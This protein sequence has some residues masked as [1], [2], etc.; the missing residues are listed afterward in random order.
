[1]K[2]RLITL[3]ALGLAA[4]QPR[5]VLPERHVPPGT[6]SFPIG[7]YTNCARG[8]GTRGPSPNA[9]LNAAGFESGSVLTLAQSGTT[10]QAT[11]VDWNG[12]TQSAS[13]STTTVTSAT[14][15]PAGQVIPGF[16]SICVMGVGVSNE[17]FHPA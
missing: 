13:F 6:I 4:C 7:T 12:L 15:A 10:V 9:F 1:M 14:L 5:V 2:A 11:Y 8:A 16:T 3:V 17:T